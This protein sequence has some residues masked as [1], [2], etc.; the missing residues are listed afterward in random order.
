[1][2]LQSVQFKKERKNTLYK[3][4]WNMDK[5]K[6]NRSQ[7]QIFEQQLSS[8]LFSRRFSIIF[9]RLH[10]VLNVMHFEWNIITVAI[11]SMQIIN[12]LFTMLIPFFIQRQLYSPSLLHNLR[13]Q[14]CVSRKSLR[15]LPT[16]YMREFLVTFQ[17][18]IE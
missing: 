17:M 8:M 4:K 14:I 15:I 5:E 3:L 6:K 1:M 13:N 18:S 7:R 16:I 9:V 2:H 10:F 11:S 12:S